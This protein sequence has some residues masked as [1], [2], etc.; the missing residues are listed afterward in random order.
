MAQAGVRAS[1]ALEAAIAM[2]QDT[3]WLRHA[4]AHSGLLTA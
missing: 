4:A 3:G 2:A 1:R